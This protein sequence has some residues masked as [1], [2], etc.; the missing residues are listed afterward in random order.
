MIVYII[1]SCYYYY[2]LLNLV[3]INIRKY[4]YVFYYL[5]VSKWILVIKF[6]IVKILYGKHGSSRFTHRIVEYVYKNISK[7]PHLKYKFL[8]SNAT[9]NIFC[10]IENGSH[11]RNH[12]RNSFDLHY[13]K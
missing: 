10:L 1:Y 9:Y 8:K 3:S 4:Y 13:R 6:I 7:K 2:R 12:S 5:F 11:S